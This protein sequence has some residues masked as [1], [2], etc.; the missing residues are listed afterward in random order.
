MASSEP[1]WQKLLSQAFPVLISGT[2]YRL[3]ESQEQVATSALVDDLDEQAILEQLLEATKPRLRPG[4]E[5]L[6]YL[7]AAPFR[8]PP[9]PWGSRFGRSFEPSLLYGALTERTCLAESAFYRLVFWSGMQTP[10][11]SGRL[12]TQHTLFSA[13]YYSHQSVRLQGPIF[14]AGLD[15][16]CHPA[17]YQQPQMLGS[18]MRS[19]GVEAF[20]Y[21]SARCPEH[22]LNVALFEPRALTSRAPE[23]QSAWIG[24]TQADYVAFSSGKTLHKFASELF[25]I[26]GQL[27]YPA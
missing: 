24:D 8:Y 5:H 4:T 22:G 25:K 16:L 2:L 7:L 17:Q 19:Q 11:A 3:V 21:P 15:Q 20:E 9:L 23:S 6:H 10:P 13:N 12:Q 26:D 1:G 14:E 18:Q 27:P